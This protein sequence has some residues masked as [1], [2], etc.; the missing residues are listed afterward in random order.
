M[1]DRALN[2]TLQVSFSFAYT[3]FVFWFWQHFNDFFFNFNNEV[4]DLI[5]S[6]MKHD[7][8]NVF[9]MFAPKALELLFPNFIVF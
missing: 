5:Y 2:S 1:I 8:G 4:I 3:A 9:H 7:S 6:G